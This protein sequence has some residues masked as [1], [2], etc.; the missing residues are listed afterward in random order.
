MTKNEIEQL[1]IQIVC[2][3]QDLS[4]RERVEV[5]LGTKPIHDMPGFDSLNGVEATIEIG[6]ELHLEFDFNN[7]LVADDKALTIEQA[8]DRLLGC[9]AKQSATQD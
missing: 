6:D 1:L 2:R 3:L 4:G 7:V 9:M 5:T 8:A